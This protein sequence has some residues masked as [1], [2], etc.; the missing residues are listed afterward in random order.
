[1][2]IPDLGEI[3]ESSRV[4]ARAVLFAGSFLMGWWACMLFG[5]SVHGTVRIGWRY[6]RGKVKVKLLVPCETCGREDDCTNK[7][8]P[9]AP[10]VCRECH[11][12]EE[13]ESCRS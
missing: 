4:A 11:T 6:A 8:L 5:E 10:Y 7:P 13:K 9:K 12:K 3:E 1:M 2:K